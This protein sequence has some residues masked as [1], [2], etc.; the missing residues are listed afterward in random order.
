MTL[1]E[2][3]EKAAEEGW[4]TAALRGASYVAGKK[5]PSYTVYRDG[6]KTGLMWELQIN[7]VNIIRQYT[8][9]SHKYKVRIKPCN[10]RPIQE[11]ISELEEGR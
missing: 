6:K 7:F 10:A 1:R 8:F 11:V 3:L 4:E 9:A 5:Y 2:C